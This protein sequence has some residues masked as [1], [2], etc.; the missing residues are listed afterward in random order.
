MAM[1]AC[2]DDFGTSHEASTYAE[3]IQ[4]FFFQNKTNRLFF[5][6]SGYEVILILLYNICNN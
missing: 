1:A 6:F 3:I 2:C 5:N 4:V